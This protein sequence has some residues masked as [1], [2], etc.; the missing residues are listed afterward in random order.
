MFKG[1]ELRLDTV[2]CALLAVKVLEGKGAEEVMKKLGLRPGSCAIVRAEEG[3]LL[4][5]KRG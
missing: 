5:E 2:W 3:R 1:V 4:V